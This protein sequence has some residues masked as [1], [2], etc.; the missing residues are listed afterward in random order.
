MT[1]IKTTKRAGAGFLGSL[2]AIAIALFLATASPALGAAEWKIDSLSN[3]TAAPSSQL[4]Y[5]VQIYNDGDASAPLETGGTTDNCTEGALPPA[6][7]SK[8]YRIVA[9]FPPGLTPVSGSK[10]QGNGDTCILAPPKITCSVD[11]NFGNQQRPARLGFPSRRVVPFVVAVEPEALGKTLT[12]SFEVSG[13]GAVADTVL[14]STKVDADSPPFGI[15]E[16]DNRSTADA[17]GAL[18]VRAGTHPYEQ[19]V[20]VEFE[21]VVNPSPAKGMLWPVEPTKDLVVDLPP[22]FVGDLSDMG[23]CSSNQLA[24]PGGLVNLTA[25]PPSSQIGVTSVRSLNPEQ[26]SIYSVPVYNMIPPPG[27]PARFGFNVLG[28]NVVLDAKLRSH[29]DY[30]ISILSRNISQGLAVQANEFVL[31]GVPASQVHDRDRVCPLSK[32]PWENGGIWC[33]TGV[34]ETPILRQPTSCTPPGVGLP[35]TIRV[36][37]WFNPAT[38]GPDGLPDLSDPNW[39]SETVISHE[40]PYYGAA[41]EDR[42]AERGIEDCE[43]APVEGELEAKPTARDTETASG[44]TVHFGVPNPGMENPKGIASS[45]IKKVKVSLPQGMTIN[46]SQAEGLGVCSPAQYEST[47]LSFYPTPGKGC[48]DDSKIGTV[49]VV[50]PLLDEKIPGNVY[51][52]QQDDPTT[53]TPGAENPFDSLLAIYIVLREPERGIMIRLA[54]K[55]ETDEKT[56]RIITTFDDLPQQ[57]FS[58]FD[59]KFREGARAPLVTPPTCGPYTTEAEI[60]GWSSV[61]PVTGKVDPA[62]ILHASSSFLID[63]GIGGGPCPPNGTPGFKPGFTAG[64]LSNRAGSFSPFTMRLTRNDGEQNLTRFSSVLPKGVLAKLAGVEQCSDTAIA[65]AKG[66]TGR[67]ELASPSCPANSLIGRSLAGAG[68]GS[69]LTYVPGKIYLAGPFHGAPIS[70]VAI[71][72]AV[73]GPFDVGAVVVREALTLDPRTGEARVD[74]T[75]SDPIPHILEGVPLKLRDLRVYVDRP[76]FTLNATSCEPAAAAATLWGSAADVFN[77]ADDLPVGLS[78]RYQAADCASLGF[79]PR[80]SIRLFGP[81]RR[82]AHPK[83]MAVV[84]ARPGD[85]NIGRAAVTLPR[86]ELLENSHIR[87]ICTRVQYG[88]KTCPPA[89]IYGYA[90]AFSPLLDQPLEGPVYLRS[91][92]NQLPDMVVS[93]DGLVHIDLVGRIDSTR[94]RIRATFEE[95]PDAPVSKF[96][97]TMQGGKKGLLVNGVNLCNGTPRARARFTGQ[98]GRPHEFHPRMRASCGSTRKPKRSPLR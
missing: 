65:A 78:S 46:P 98:N 41:P 19:A 74:G 71:T 11:G 96:V 39:D 35:T 89:S 60:T 51:I 53:S 93:L 81:P 32:V 21:S 59:F 44:L 4:T 6:D 68:V 25:C 36:G 34:G 50:T 31:W 29:S 28:T 84:K 14:D 3:P 87:T 94:G 63:R 8:C 86:T 72:P 73:A 27:I 43:D 69:V 97:L 70:I 40:A 52:A 56:G 91:S 18:S 30:G 66:K 45:D 85:A 77:P 24:T 2:V 83:L 57:P 22:G 61:D 13:A 75:A 5:I 10:I 54:G 62:D 20:Q 55:V 49:E 23:Q 67:A 15:G 64:T 76:D 48:P 7:P 80:L 58:S 16:F 1:T 82:A 88:E 26:N 47:V 79:K 17:S 33:P 90:R 37:S 95:I 92:D 9:T 42:G 38:F 12:A